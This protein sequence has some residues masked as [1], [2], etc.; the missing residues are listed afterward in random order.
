MRAIVAFALSPAL[1]VTLVACHKP[2]TQA[3]STTPNPSATASPTTTVQADV[4]IDACSLLTREELAAVQGCAFTGAQGSA[5]AQ[6]EFRV[7]Q[8]VYTAEEPNKSV[9]LVLMRNKSGGA[10]PRTIK[11]FWDETFD[12]F[13]DAEKDE[14]RKPAEKRSDASESRGKDE[15]DEEG[16][17]PPLRIEGLG[18]SAFW[19][20]NHVGGTL[21]VL[22]GDA[23]IRISVGGPAGARDVRMKNTQQL[24]EKVLTR[25]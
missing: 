10:K 15:E 2:P 5:S 25:L 8:C 23:L 22:K 6:G 3:H 20:N 21:Y 12:R 7:A 24:A 17:P 1:L 13:D 18:D 16:K 14:D 4:E 19:I 11:Q 9:S